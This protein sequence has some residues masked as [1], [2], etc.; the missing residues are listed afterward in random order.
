MLSLRGG[1][2]ATLS[3]TGICLLSSAVIGTTLGFGVRFRCSILIGLRSAMKFCLIETFQR[4]AD[5]QQIVDAECS[6]LLIH[7]VPARIQW[8]VQA[9][10]D[11]DFGS[12][13]PVTASQS[14][15][16]RQLRRPYLDATNWS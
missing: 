14:E 1:G 10:T 5:F 6:R 2:S 9:S 16:G 15:R 8:H 7:A 11:A 3:V 12:S 13:V 4:A